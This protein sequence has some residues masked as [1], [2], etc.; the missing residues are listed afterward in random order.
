MNPSRLA[1]LLLL[2]A[3][4]SAPAQTNG[5][6]V[7]DTGQAL[8]FDTNRVIDPPLPEE[9]FHG[10][11][12]QHEGNAPAYRDNEDGTVTDLVTGLTWV[13]TRGVKMTFEEAVLGA[14]TCHAGG[15][16]DWRLPT[17]KELYSLIQFTGSSGRTAQDSVPYLD[18]NRFEFAFGD[19]WQG[20]RLID[21][22]DWS[23]TEYTGLT[24]GRDAAVFGVNFADGRI[25]AYP[26]AMRQRQGTRPTRLFARYV[27]GGTNYGVNQFIDQGNGT[28]TDAA[29]GLMWCQADSGTAMDW[30]SALAWVAQ[31]NRENHLGH[32]DW[33]LPNAKELQSLV[34][35][36]RSPDATQSPAIDPLFQTTALGT[37]EWPCFWTSTTHLEG[38]PGHKGTAA[39]YVAF[40]RALGWMSFPPRFDRP[41]LIDV[42]GAGAQRSDPKVGDPADFPRGRGPQ[43]DL[44]R[45]RN[46][47]RLVRGG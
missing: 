8:C 43:G 4:V 30:P 17:V 38:P 6:P 28:V 15:H 44:I 45:I 35:Y 40:G 33:R 21:C 12:A 24:M 22:Q 47:V 41:Q 5:Y 39:V 26:K 2:A 18:T 3:A 20:E 9:P 36:T 7:V 37:N 13:K 46:F 32:N 19:M 27:R 31:N 11:D 10:Q 25:K 16:D 1:C 23:A 29:T 14:V 42:H 34:D